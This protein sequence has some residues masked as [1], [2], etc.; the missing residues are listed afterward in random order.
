VNEWPPA[1]ATPREWFIRALAGVGLA[2]AAT[3]FCVRPGYLGL[4]LALSGF[5]ACS[6][7]ALMELLTRIKVEPAGRVTSKGPAPGCCGY[8]Q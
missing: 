6:I 2:L 8:R 1:P 4:G 7:C 3:S 5:L